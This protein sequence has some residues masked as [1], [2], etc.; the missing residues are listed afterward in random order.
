MYR[1]A[2]LAPNI[3]LKNVRKLAFAGIPE[4]AGLR[5]R[6][7]KLLFAYLPLN[8]EDEQRELRS[9][10]EIFQQFREE[11][12]IDPQR[13]AA[14]HDHPLSDGDDS[15][16]KK[17]FKD[18]ELLAEIEKDATRTFP[19]LH[20]FNHDPTQGETKHYEALR[21]I[22]FI[23]AKLNPGIKY[24]QGMN[25]LL[26]PIYYIFA[27]AVGDVDKCENH[28]KCYADAEADAFFVFTSLMAEVM[29]NFIKTLDKSDVGVHAEMRNMNELLKAKDPQLWSNLE[30]KGLSPQFY[31]FRWITLLLSQEFELPDLLRLWDSLFADPLLVFPFDEIF[32]NDI[33]F[34]KVVRNELFLGDF[35]HN[36]KLLQSYPSDGE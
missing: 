25:E 6:Y 33:V 36:L 21:R 15:T 26:A 18:N 31:S 23:Y 29:N 1:E 24:I 5:A 19:Q 28:A 35:A 12:I 16:W 34:C 14:E 3:N 8:R 32:F 27:T 10:R 20:F 13:K 7:W 2:V 17:Y 30:S 11:F 9:R 4:E 22:L